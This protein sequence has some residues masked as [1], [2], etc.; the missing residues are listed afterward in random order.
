MYGYS[1]PKSGAEFDIGLSQMSKNQNPRS[2]RTTT[3]PH[4]L[5]RLR[6]SENLE[7]LIDIEFPIAKYG[8]RSDRQKAF[9]KA[10]GLSWSTIQRVLTGKVSATT[11]TLVD[12]AAVFGI[13][14]SD[15]LTSN[16]SQTYISRTESQRRSA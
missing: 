15:L 1:Q 8:T 9:A 16:F 6:L 7:A 13:S 3:A 10:A 2:A 12:L 14:P 4:R 11:D 5:A